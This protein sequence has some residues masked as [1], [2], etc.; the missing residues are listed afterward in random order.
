MDFGLLE[1]SSRAENATALD[2]NFPNSAFEVTYSSPVSFG[3][4]PL[5]VAVKSIVFNIGPQ[6]NANALDILDVYVLSNLVQA[7]MRIGNS[8]Q[9]VLARLEGSQENKRVRIDVI[10]PQ[11]QKC[12]L[13]TFSRVTL[14]L[15][16]NSFITTK[17]TQPVMHNIHS[18]DDAN[19]TV[20]TLMFRPRRSMAGDLVGV[21]GR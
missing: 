7:T 4:G 10:N 21:G 12:A 3:E 9:P 2:V 1:I 16:T 14:R 18:P 5:D 19:A 8:K 20:V 17:G 11:W 6:E 13:S 15:A